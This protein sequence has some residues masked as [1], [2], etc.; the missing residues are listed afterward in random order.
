MES[1]SVFYSLQRVIYKPSHFLSFG[2]SCMP[3]NTKYWVP[4]F[5]YQLS[6]NDLSTRTSLG[7]LSPLFNWTEG[8]EIL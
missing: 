8:E 1:L 6:L 5:S 3:E 7:V 2:S 4:S